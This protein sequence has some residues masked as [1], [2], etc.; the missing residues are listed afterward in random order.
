[1]PDVLVRDVN[2]KVIENL[3]RRAA[4]NGRSLQKELKEILEKSAMNS[5]KD[6][7]NLA[8]KIRLKIAAGG[9]RQSDSVELIRED[10]NR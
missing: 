5:K 7:I 10:R 2:E 1:M 9:K 4:L 3:K 6:Y 8:E